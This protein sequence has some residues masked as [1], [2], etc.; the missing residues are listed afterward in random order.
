LLDWLEQLVGLDEVGIV[1]PGELGLEA[2]RASVA[3]SAAVTVE[4]V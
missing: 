3:S 4:C 1:F 2:L